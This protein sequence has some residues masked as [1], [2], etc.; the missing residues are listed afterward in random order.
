MTHFYSNSCGFVF[1]QQ[2]RISLTL[3]SSD[4]AKPH[5]NAN[6]VVTN[7]ESLVKR[8]LSFVAALR[9]VY[10]STGY[11]PDQQLVSYGKD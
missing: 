11:H 8:K 6:S 5:R 9:Q 7:T 2:E 1:N 4:V 10:K 3:F